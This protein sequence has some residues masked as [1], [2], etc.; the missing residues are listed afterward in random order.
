MSIDGL[1]ADTLFNVP[2]LGYNYDDLLSLPGPPM[3]SVDE[4]DLTTL[5]SKSVQL[6]T[7]IVAA[8]MDTVCESRMAIACALAGGIGV[9]HCNCDPERQAQEVSTVKH[10]ENGFIMDP[11]VLSP[12]ST[13]G[14]LEQIR[15][16]H[17]AT[18]VMVTDGGQM[19]KKLLG[20]VTSRDADLAV[21][22]KTKISDLMTPKHKMVVALEPISLSEAYQKL[23]VSKKG[24][25]PILNEAGELVAVVSRGDLKKNRKYPNAARDAN[26]QL[27]V[28]AACPPRAAELDRARTLIE[29]GADAIVV[30]SSQG[31]SLTQIDFLKRLKK[32]FPNIDVVC[33]N[34]VTPKQA[35]ALLDAGADGLRVGMGCSSLCSGQE[36]CSVGRPQA[37]AVYH[38]ARFAAEGYGVP[39]IADGGCTGSCHISMA[40]TLG[41]STVMCGSLLAGTSE[42]PGEAFFHDGMRLKLYRGMGVLDVIPGNIPT[43]EAL[44]PRE[45]LSA[46]AA[47]GIAVKEAPRAVPGGISCAVVE[48]GPASSILPYLL[49]GVKRDLRR[50]GVGTLTQLHSALYKS[51]TRFH[52]RSPGA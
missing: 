48:R 41:A 22:I 9:I 34:V 15:Q 33:G 50:L 32:D 7:P 28:A 16:E 35:K 36:V 51:Q 52:V 6:N 10:H 18:T 8:P 24:K 3:H 13:L 40:L 23:R 42:S 44:V 12:H 4:V 31:D 46:S 17:G 1:D 11:H 47:T 37:S 29:A 30:D 45:E 21:D 25:L 49:D 27:L 26:R 20:I 14:E 43:S 39:V 5:F 38:V 19:G 2:C